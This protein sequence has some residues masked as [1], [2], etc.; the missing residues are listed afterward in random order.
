VLLV[1]ATL[2][3]MM[4]ICIVL[5]LCSFV[6][7]LFVLCDFSNGVYVNRSSGPE[8]DLVLYVMLVLRIVY[9]CNVDIMLYQVQ[10]N[11]I[12]FK[13]V[14]IVHFMVISVIVVVVAVGM[15]FVCFLNTSF[16]MVDFD[17]G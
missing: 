7:I 5:V 3:D 8:V 15:R 4:C 6:M 11:I 9:F 2:S 10:M 14:N 1:D 13:P 12:F 16:S 17:H